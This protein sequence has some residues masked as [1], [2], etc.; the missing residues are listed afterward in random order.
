MVAA[1]HLAAVQG[2]AEHLA[3]V[4]EVAVRKAAVRV[5]GRRVWRRL[6]GI[7]TAVDAVG[8]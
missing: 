8:S 3:A 6:T 5:A 2:V 7:W 4:Q 1:G